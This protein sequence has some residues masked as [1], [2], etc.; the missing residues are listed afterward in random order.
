MDCCSGGHCCNF[1]YSISLA[2]ESGL[3]MRLMNLLR[4][5]NGAPVP[6]FSPGSL[7]SLLL[8]LDPSDADGRDGSGGLYDLSE[9]GHDYTTK[10]TGAATKPT[11]AT[12]PNGNG[13]YYFLPGGSSAGLQAT[14]WNGPVSGA[15]P[16]EV[17]FIFNVNNPDASGA[18]I[19]Q[20]AEL[21][22]GVFTGTD[23]GPY[24]FSGDTMPD[25]KGAGTKDTNYHL[26]RFVYD[27]GSQSSV[28]S[29]KFYL[30][31]V[32]QTLSASLTPYPSETPTARL[33]ANIVH[34]QNFDGN[35]G[36]LVVTGGAALTIQ[37]AADLTS[38]FAAKWAITIA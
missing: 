35:L 38:Y 15:T 6:P 20:F 11:L 17:W 24:L 1:S 3:F 13:V 14:A 37:D 27:G 12:G 21:G 16:Y 10:T 33:G 36:E 34:G 32:E 19:V 26:F 28:S 29:Y 22:L 30:D 25:M 18:R 9:N 7:S 5:S 4:L 8:W 2:L 23:Y 31:G